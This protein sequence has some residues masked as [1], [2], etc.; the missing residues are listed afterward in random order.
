MSGDVIP[1]LG[2]QLK[3]TAKKSGNSIPIY[4]E[5]NRLIVNPASGNGELTSMLEKWYKIQ[6]AT[7]IQEKVDKWS[8]IL[9]VR[10]N[11]VTI[12]GQRSRWGSCSRK[13]N[14]NF[15]WKLMM[16]PETIIDYVVIHELAHLQQMNHSKKFW[17]I[18]A[19]NCPEWRNRKKWLRNNEALLVGGLQM[20]LEL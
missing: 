13:G 11:K 20:K 2:K 6:A 14:L 8:V 9:S 18:V 19:A 1:Y 7:L 17:Q 4:L 3:I 10:P 5:R 16:A 15:N 12:R